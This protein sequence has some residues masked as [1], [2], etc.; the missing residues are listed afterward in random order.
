MHLA[1]TM[2][3]PRQFVIETPTWN[4]PIQPF[5]HPYALIP[6]PAIGGRHLEL[7]RYDGHGIRGTP[8]ELRRQMNAVT[9]DAVFAAIDETM[10][11]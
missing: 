6:N 11:K 5:N 2:R 7:Y 8:E 4:K 3:V 10:P 9:V 1:A